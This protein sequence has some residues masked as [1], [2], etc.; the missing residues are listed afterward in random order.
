MT[1]LLII[2]SVIVG[3]GSSPAAA[4]DNPAWLQHLNQVRAEAGV[5]PLTINHAWDNGER[6]HSCYMALNNKVGHDEDPSKPGY[7]EEGLYA[8]MSSNAAAYRLGATPSEFIDRWLA[9][10]F[11]ALAMLRPGLTQT[12]FG[13]C[14]SSDLTFASLDVLRGNPSGGAR[15]LRTVVFPGPNA[16]TNLDRFN[17]EYPNPQTACGL[18]DKPGLPAV[19]MFPSPIPA[20]ASVS[21]EVSGPGVNGKTEVIAS[22]VLYKNKPGLDSL[23]TQHLGDN[24]IIIMPSR[25]LYNGR[26]TIRLD[27][28]S[29]TANWSFNV[30]GIC[31]GKQVTIVGTPGSDTIR[32]T[33]GN[34]VIYAGPGRDTINGGGGNDTICGSD[35]HDVIDGGAGNDKIVGGAG[36]DKIR[37]GGGYDIVYGGVGNDTIDGGGARDEL[38]GEADDDIVVGGNGNDTVSGGAGNDK[39]SGGNGNDTVSGNN[40]DDRVNGAGGNDKVN[41]GNGNDTLF[42]SDGIDALGGGP[43]RDQLYGG[44]GDDKLYGNDG[45]DLLDGGAGN[46][47]MVGGPDD[48]N[49][50]GRSGYDVLDGGAGSD[51]AHGGPNRDRCKAEVTRSCEA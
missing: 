41:G 14:D 6:L 33:A 26:Y 47:G 38:Y 3:T 44:N 4:N 30:W 32:G 48:D 34:D 12:S 24:E 42:G 19:A 7:T 23:Y 9:A 5:G 31:A 45:N 40:G 51:R 49:L 35:G 13:S 27:A 25:I 39:L 16:T 10:P 46:D 8:G 11:H 22:C 15:P 43:G 36:N 50:L 2:G 20:G 17:G 21:A 37:G 18:H 28:G 29:Q 1:I